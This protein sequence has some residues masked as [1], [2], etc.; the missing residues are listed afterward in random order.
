[1]MV[2][3][4]GVVISASGDFNFIK[5]NQFVDEKHNSRIPEFMK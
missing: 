3:M 2:R 4:F 5:R 1:M